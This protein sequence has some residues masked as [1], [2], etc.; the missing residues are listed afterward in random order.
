MVN[1][2]RHSMLATFAPGRPD[3]SY[4]PPK[5]YPIIVTI[6]LKM[7]RLFYHSDQPPPRSSCLSSRQR[8][9]RTT[10]AMPMIRLILY[11]F[12][13][14]LSAVAL[15]EPHTNHRSPSLISPLFSQTKSSTTLSLPFS[16]TKNNETQPK[17]SSSSDGSSATLP[18]S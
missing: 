6:D 12:V 9:A 4:L 15:S 17:H 14:F 1:A 5:T 2:G 8:R 16:R 3:F 10:C 13:R 18:T 11:D 7:A